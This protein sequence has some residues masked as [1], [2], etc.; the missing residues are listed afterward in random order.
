LPPGLRSPRRPCRWLFAD[1]RSLFSLLP[2]CRR[3]HDVQ[4]FTTDAQA[5]AR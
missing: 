4:A 3:R 2:F 5:L 1:A